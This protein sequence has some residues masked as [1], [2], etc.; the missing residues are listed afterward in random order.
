MHITL[1][2]LFRG[3]KVDLRMVSLLHPPVALIA[4]HP[5]L[6]S[7]LLDRF[8][9][10]REAPSL[11]FLGQILEILGIPAIILNIVSIRAV[12]SIMPT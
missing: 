10:V 4:V 12:S 1:C 9:L 5:R 6:A 3:R 8:Y 2:S 11:A 7:S